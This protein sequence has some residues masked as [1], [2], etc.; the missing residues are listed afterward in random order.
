M[1][2]IPA[3]AF[4][5]SLD[6]ELA[7]LHTRLAFEYVTAGQPG[8]ALD[9]ASKAVATGRDY[10]PA[11]LA[12]AHVNAVLTRRDDAERDF[13]QALALT[14]ENGEANNNFGLFLCLSGR[15]QDGARHLTRALS[16]PRY[17]ARETA[18]L[19]LGRCSLMAGE[20][21][22]AVEHWLAALRA[23]PAYPSAL[24][25]LAVMYTNQGSV[26]RASY[27]FGRLIEHAGPLEADDLLLGV[28]LAR[29]SG[30]RVREEAYSGELHTRFPDSR[31]TQQLLSGI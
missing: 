28:R 1:M 2:A 6:H 29:L 31:E 15:W 13:R 17:G 25:Q 22:Q 19:N 23:K 3:G 11:W 18:Y 12:R 24:R 14:P 10:A 9:A 21:Q 27:Y 5:T 7:S 4:A 20:T 16:D 8:L 26:E 30:D